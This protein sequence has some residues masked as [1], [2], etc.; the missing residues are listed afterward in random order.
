MSTTI[1][2]KEGDYLSTETPI[3]GTLRYALSLPTPR[4][5]IVTVPEIQLRDYLT[6]TSSYLNIQSAVGTFIK[7]APQIAIFSGPGILANITV[8]PSGGNW[9]PIVFGGTNCQNWLVKDCVSIANED[10]GFNAYLGASRI[11]F[12][13]CVFKGWPKGS[14]VDSA[15]IT[16]CTNITYDNCLF[17]GSDIRMPNNAG[18]GVT[19]VK[20]STIYP[21]SSGL[22][23]QRLGS[24]TNIINNIFIGRSIFDYFPARIQTIPLDTLNVIYQ[25]ENRWF[26]DGIEQ[27]FK[28]GQA[29]LYNTPI[30]D[31]M[32]SLT[33]F[34]CLLPDLTGVPV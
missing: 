20:N 3:Q 15:G 23:T 12:D 33:P 10:D 1:V 6:I 17:K 30:P 19:T 11:L 28:V 27:T 14:L 18:Q 21:G 13:R 32:Y 25:S 29:G 2:N 22:E 31:S 9:R 24:Q 8:I 34:P 26:V 16:P 4:R 7:A 5:I